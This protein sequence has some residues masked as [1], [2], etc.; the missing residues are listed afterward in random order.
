MLKYLWLRDVD[1]I[2][3]RTTSTT[4]IC[5][6]TNLSFSQDVALSLYNSA[7][8]HPINLDDAWQ[9]LGY[10]TKQK[11]KNKLTSNFELNLDYKAFNQT[12]ECADG[13]GSSRREVITLT[14]LPIY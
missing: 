1:S 13:K 3:A 2:Q 11:A 14:I 10:S 9:W 8:S 4:G 5:T 6:M 7:D 12:V